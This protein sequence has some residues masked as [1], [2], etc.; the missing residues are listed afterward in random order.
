MTQALIKALEE[1]AQKL[2]TGIKALTDDDGELKGSENRAKFERMMGE[3]HGLEETI[4]EAKDAE[5]EELRS[6][7]AGAQEEGEKDKTGI[8]EFRSF[9][10]L[11]DDRMPQEQR[12]SLVAGTDANGGYLV[13]E[14]MHAQMLDLARKN[15]PILRLATPFNLT[16]SP[17]VELPFKATHGLVATATETGAR[18]E[19]NAP[20]IGNNTLTCFE[21][22]TDQRATQAYLDEVQNAETML[23]EWIYGDIVEQ[24]EA[25]AV[26]GDGSG[27]CSGLFS[28]TGYRSQATAAD[29]TVTASDMID[30]YF[31]LGASYRAKAV[32]LCNSMVMS[33]IAKMTHPAASTTIPFATMDASGN[34]TV[35]GRRIEEAENA[36]SV[37]KDACPV[38]FADVARAYAA[39]F[40]KNTSILRD[41]YTAT[42]KVRFYAY[43]RIGGRPWDDNACV[44]LKATAATQS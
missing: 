18:T 30:Q 11:G 21:Y 5:L 42:P 7:L 40:H 35:M 4:R 15:N 32:W 14:N 28:H 10:R 12:A 2:E 17:S 34:M 6:R 20:T 16:G 33:A 38:A 37:A 19:K 29:A 41:P 25:D 39:G 31:K 36:P 44:L 23:M 22:Y 27:K 8:A 1:R 9:L 24:A 3:M 26:D 43:A 13:P